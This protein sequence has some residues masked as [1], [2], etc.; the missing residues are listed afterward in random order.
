M[1]AHDQRYRSEEISPY[2]SK[3]SRSIAGQ[4]RRQVRRERLRHNK[5]GFSPGRRRITS[6]C[7]CRQPILPTTLNISIMPTQVWRKIPSKCDI[8]LNGTNTH[9]PDITYEKGAELT[10]WNNIAKLPIHINRKFFGIFHA[11]HMASNH[12][13]DILIV[14]SGILGSAS[15]R[16]G[17]SP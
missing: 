11:I 4:Q 16:G 8:C 5:V 12:H 3:S 2:W 17:A 10:R 13:F 9:K 6:C 15:K 7:L 1:S 14:R